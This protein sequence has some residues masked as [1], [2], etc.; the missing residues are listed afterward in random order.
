MGLIL[1]NDWRIKPPF[2]RRIGEELRRH[3][4][5]ELKDMKQLLHTAAYYPQEIERY[6][7]PKKPA[8]ITAAS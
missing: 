1:R 5:S 4:M 6:M 8:V 3:S 2:A 7:N